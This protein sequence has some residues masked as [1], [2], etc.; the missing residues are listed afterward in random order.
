M[1]SSKRLSWSKCRERLWLRSSNSEFRRLTPN[2]QVVVPKST[3]PGK[4]LYLPQ[5]PAEWPGIATLFAIGAAESLRLRAEITKGYGS[6][7]DVSSFLYPGFDPLGLAK[8]KSADE[9]KVWR[10]K[11]S[12]LSFELHDRKS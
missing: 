4:L 12:I 1:Y 11:V 7:E 2:S 6:Y 9:V 5:V 3:R 8:G 10:T